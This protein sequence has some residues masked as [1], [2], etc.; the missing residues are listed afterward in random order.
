MSLDITIK[1][2]RPKRVDYNATHAVCGSNVTVCNAG[3]FF[4]DT[5][6]E[7]N[8]THNMAEMARHI[9]VS[10]KYRNKNYNGTLYDYVWHP[11]KHGNVTT[12]PMSRILVS[13]IAYMVANRKEL[14]LH[15]PVNG[16][17]SYDAFLLWLTKYKEVCEDNSGCKIIAEG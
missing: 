5:E 11:D 8:I 13:G 14:L 16:W 3:E 9:P 1:Y 12:A 10:V 17:G 2:K 6:W 15:N 4:E 7:A